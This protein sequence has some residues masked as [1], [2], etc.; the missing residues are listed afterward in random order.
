MS[1]LSAWWAQDGGRFAL[2]YIRKPD[3]QTHDRAWHLV[4]ALGGEDYEPVTWT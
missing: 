3:A 4:S 2:R 1:R